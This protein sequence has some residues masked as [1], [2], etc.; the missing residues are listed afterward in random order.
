MSG[1]PFVVAV[2]HASV[3]QPVMLTLTPQLTSH[4]ELWAER[5]YTS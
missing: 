4:C 1:L 5:L 3:A 2:Q